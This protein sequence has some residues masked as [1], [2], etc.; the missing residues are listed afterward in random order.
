VAQPQ[1]FTVRKAII[2]VLMVGWLVLLLWGLERKYDESDYR[3]T[4]QLL[5]APGAAWSL[6]KELL[7][8]NPG[9]APH[10]EKELIS[11]FR[12]LVRLTCAASGVEP[13]RFEVD[14]VRRSFRGL[15]PRSEEVVAAVERRRRPPDA[16]G[17]PPDSGDR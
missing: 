8:R 1:P 9:N 10:C 11:S 6:E 16:G 15:D 14:L 17:Q 5:A 4:D 7:E 13:W 3:K 12:G 2:G